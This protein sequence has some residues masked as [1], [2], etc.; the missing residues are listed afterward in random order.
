MTH[1]HSY[2]KINVECEYCGKLIHLAKDCTQ[3]YK[4]N[5]GNCVHKDT[6]INDGFKNI[7]LFISESM[8]SSETDDENA[9][10]I[11]Y[12]ASTHM[13]CNKE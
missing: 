3:R 10:F 6:S 13:T 2:V 1:S 7:K 4:R 9:W 12:G 11:D 8:L 5:N